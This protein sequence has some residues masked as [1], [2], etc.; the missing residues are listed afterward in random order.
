MAKA[1]KPLPRSN[2]KGDLPDYHDEAV[3]HTAFK[4]YLTDSAYPDLPEDIITRPIEW[5]NA[6]MWARLEL[7][8]KIKGYEK[9][10]AKKKGEGE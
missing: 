2:T 4:W 9:F 7:E 5:D 3:L 10:M 1:G 8:T 6:I